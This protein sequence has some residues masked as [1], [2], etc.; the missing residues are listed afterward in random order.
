MRG[1]GSGEKPIDR[2]RRGN[3]R[4]G[5]SQ[6]INVKRGRSRSGSGLGREREGFAKAFEAPAQGT[7]TMK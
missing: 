5:G 3:S 7:R 2:A 4:E 6:S 1:S